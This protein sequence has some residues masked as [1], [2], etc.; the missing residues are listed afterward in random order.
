[1]GIVSIDVG[2][3]GKVTFCSTYIS[4]IIITIIRYLESKNP[5]SDLSTNRLR[6]LGILLFS[7]V[8]SSK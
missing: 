7:R 6:E 5:D 4:Q 3:A 8:D 1:M 2:F